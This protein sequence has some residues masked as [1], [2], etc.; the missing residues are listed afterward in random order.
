M[1]SLVAFLVGV[2]FAVGL[3]IGGMTQP[4]RVLAF[5]DVT[6]AW[7][8]G[9]AFVMLGGVATYGTLFPL[10]MRRRRPLLAAA[11]DVP[12]RRDLDLRLAGG[13]AI[14]GIGWGLAGLCPGPAL[15]ALASGEP[16]AALFV[17]CMVAGMAAHRAS[18]R[19]LALLGAPLAEK[20]PHGA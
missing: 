14:F 10:V 9:L 4:A 17:V 13:A 18:E 8:P 3:G 20:A 12:T 11:F 2:V 6:G 1:R 7:D 19:C 5:L 16:G 15:A